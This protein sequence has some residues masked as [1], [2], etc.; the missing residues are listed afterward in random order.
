MPG[1]T[2]TGRVMVAGG[3]DGIAPAV[4]DAAAPFKSDG[5]ISSATLAAREEED[6]TTIGLVSP[7]ST[8]PIGPISLYS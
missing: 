1:L 3:A 8:S 5:A 6:V 7:I 4:D 2:G